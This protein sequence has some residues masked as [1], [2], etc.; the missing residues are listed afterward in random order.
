MPSS[1]D[2][3]RAAAAAARRGAGDTPARGLGAPVRR[4]LGTLQPASPRRSVPRRRGADRTALLR[5]AVA[6]SS[7]SRIPVATPS[8]RTAACSL[9]TNK[10]RKRGQKN[11]GDAAT[12]NAALAVLDR[13]MREMAQ[14]IEQSRTPSI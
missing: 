8:P 10:L 12:F 1:G 9:G 11:A 6:R 14:A 5:S 7:S 13:D 4:A 3:A 2:G